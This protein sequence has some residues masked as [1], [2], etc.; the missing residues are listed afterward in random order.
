MIFL[1]L[2]LSRYTLQPTTRNWGQSV[3]DSL[4]QKSAHES[5]E[6]AEIEVLARIIRL[7]G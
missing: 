3:G 4:L 1:V 7:N 5:G 6:V 2:S